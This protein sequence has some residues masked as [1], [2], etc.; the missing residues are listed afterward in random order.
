MTITFRCRLVATL[1]A[2]IMKVALAEGSGPWRIYGPSDGLAASPTLSVTASPRGLLWARHG[3]GGAISWLDGFQI[4]ALPAPDQGGFPVYESRSGQIWSLHPEGLVEFRRDQWVPYPVPAIRDEFRSNSLRLVRPIPLLP[5]E[6]DHVLVLLS[7]RLVKFSASQRTTD[8]L[9]RADDTRLGR[10]N[11][12]VEARDGGAWL[13]GSKG[14]ARLPSPLRRISTDSPWTE[15]MPNPEWQVQDLEHP[16]EDDDGGVTVVANSLS[17]SNRVLLYYN[18][19]NWESPIPAPDRIRQAWRTP[20]QTFLAISRR[21][22]WKWEAD[23]WETVPFSSNSN[24]PPQLFDVAVQPNGLFWLAT[25]DGLVRYSPPTWRAPPG[26]PAARVVTGGVVE[27]LQG[28]VWFGTREGLIVVRDRKWELVPWP[29]APNTPVTAHESLHLLNGAQPAFRQD[30]RLG[31]YHPSTGRFQTFAPASG[32]QVLAVL[33]SLLNGNLWVQTTPPGATGRFRLE[34][35]DGQAFT[36]VLEPGADWTL[37]RTLYFV[38][39]AE[40]KGIWIGGSE[41]IGFVDLRVE[42]HVVSRDLPGGPITALLETSRGRV[43]CGGQNGVFEFDGRNWLHLPAAPMRVKTLRKALDAGIWAATGQGAFR[44]L[45]G[46]WVANSTAEGLSAR[47]LL[48]VWPDRQGNVWA[49]S[50]AGIDQFHPAADVDPPAGSIS[51]PSNPREISTSDRMKILFS[52]RDKWDQTTADR[53]LY[54]HRLDERSWTPYSTNEGVTLTNLLAGPHRVDVRAMDRTWNEMPEAA[55]HE[56]IAVVPWFQEP[57]LLAMTAAGLVIIAGLTALAVNRHLRLRKSY[58][59][60]G[61]IVELRTRELERANE[62]LLHSQKMRALG[63]LAAGIA[64]DFNN[65]LSIIKG[66]AQI[67][68]AHPDDLEKVRTRVDRIKTV[69]GQG[70][71]I[72]N[73]MLGLSRVSSRK[74]SECDVNQLVAETARLLGDQFLKGAT[75]RLETAPAVPR[76]EAATELIRQLLLNLIIN[77]ADATNGQG[78]I[79]LRTEVVEHLPAGLVLTPDKAARFVGIGVGDTGPG[80]PPEILSRIFEPFFTTKAL[81]TNRGT[82]L[83]L[84]MVYEIAKELGYGIEVDSLPGQG[85]TFT[86]LLPVPAESAGSGT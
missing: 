44:F 20:D 34:S 74:Q 70:T 61:R 41:G 18:G 78:E 36:P 45:D 63:T 48:D 84:S 23:H 4:H 53:L 66:S 76:I 7:D 85:T 86:I 35:F 27:D 49:V 5:A 22:L 14:L 56:F 40:D 38:H 31:I 11:D 68:E 77:A 79:V 72:V 1:V 73:A 46:S 17:S 55:S 58:G 65:I 81:S 3:S 26:L 71:S 42:P 64:H 30:G 50:T 9:R 75:I 28:R 57:R 60:V 52:G 62:E 82:G 19:Q 83:G 2:G 54:S 80:I 21:A 47:E 33:G 25:S 59:E 29:D 69:V 32:R 51:A 39:E 67:I 16:I 6:R 43:W 24:P 8:L 15:L 10:F 12:L 37:G 13:A